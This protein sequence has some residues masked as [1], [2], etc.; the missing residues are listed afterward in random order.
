MKIIS[1]TVRRTANEILGVKGFVSIIQFLWC[2]LG[3]FGFGSTTNLLIDF[4]FF[5]HYLSAWY[6]VDTVR[7]NSVLVSH[8]SLS[9]NRDCDTIPQLSNYS[10]KYFLHFWDDKCKTIHDTLKE[11]TQ[12]SH[13]YS[14]TF[15]CKKIFLPQTNTKSLL[16]CNIQFLQ[17]WH[18]RWYILFHGPLETIQK[19]CFSKHFLQ[20]Q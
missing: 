20:V 2:L 17:I 19:Q 16:L 6:H 3:E 9:V 18:A 14:V 1:Q 8:G 12:F 7:R 4:F 5:S 10:T 15:T 13:K 11:H